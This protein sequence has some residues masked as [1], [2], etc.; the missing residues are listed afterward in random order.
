[1]TER[2]EASTTRPVGLVGKEV[3]DGAVAV[4]ALCDMAP[5]AAQAAVVMRSSGLQGAVS[6]NV[7]SCPSRPSAT[8]VEGD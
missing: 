8:G 7:V 4:D 1:M 3:S 5:L 6:H 2:I